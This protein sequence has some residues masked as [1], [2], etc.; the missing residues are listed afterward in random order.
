MQLVQAKLLTI[1]IN[2]YKAVPFDSGSLSEGIMW[3]LNNEEPQDLNNAARKKA[4]ES[5]DVDN[6]AYKYSKLYESIVTKNGLE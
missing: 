4:L 5:F 6:A 2:G 3:V 1:K